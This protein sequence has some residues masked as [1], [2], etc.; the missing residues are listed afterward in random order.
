VLTYWFKVLNY[1]PTKVEKIFHVKGA[2][3][4]NYIVMSPQTDERVVE[5]FRQAFA[6]IKT[7]PQYQQILD[8]Y[9]K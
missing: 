2:D 1:D 3:G 9:L 4:E 7:T 5:H 8:K 6:R